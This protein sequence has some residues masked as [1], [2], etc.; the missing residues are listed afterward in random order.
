VTTRTLQAFDTRSHR[1]APSLRRFLWRRL[2]H[3]DQQDDVRHDV[4]LVAW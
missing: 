2:S 3:P 1:Y 4:L